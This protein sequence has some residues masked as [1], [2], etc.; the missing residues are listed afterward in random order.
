MHNFGWFQQRD[1]FVNV[2]Q[3]YRL[4]PRR[5]QKEFYLGEF[6]YPFF[7]VTVDWWQLTVCGQTRQLWNRET[8]RKIVENENSSRA[9]NTSKA[10]KKLSK[11]ERI[12]AFLRTLTKIHS[13][14]ASS[15]RKS[16][17]PPDNWN[18]CYVSDYCYCNTGTL[19]IIFLLVVHNHY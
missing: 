8:R 10:T 9:T 14:L 5:N 16:Q 13:V 1:H 19:K 11:T 4:C 17:G 12:H 18:D 7:S 15:L 2:V 3:F 6:S